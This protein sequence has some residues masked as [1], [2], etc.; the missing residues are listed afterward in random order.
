MSSTEESSQLPEAELPSG[1]PSD[2]DDTRPRQSPEAPEVE[3]QRDSNDP[4][5]RKLNHWENS[6]FAVGCV[7]VTWNDDNPLKKHPP[8]HEVN[9]Q[10]SWSGVCCGCLGVRRVGNMAV[11]H[12]KMREYEDVEITEAGEQIIV[13]KKRPALICMVGPYW[14]INFCITWPLVLG[15]SIWTAWSRLPDM[16]IGIIVT[17]GFCVLLLISSLFLVSCSNPGILYRHDE[18]PLGCEGD[19]RWNDQAKTYRPAHARFDNECQQLTQVLLSEE[20]SNVTITQ[21]SPIGVQE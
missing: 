14:P 20:T 3:A 19:W 6:V 17:Y 13:R 9:N 4:R 5:Q 12:Q 10:V 16:H 15:L 11:C 7:N 21:E 8:G 1:A 18:P 2:E